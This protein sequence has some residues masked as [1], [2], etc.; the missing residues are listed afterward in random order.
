MEDYNFIYQFDGNLTDD[1]GKT[2]LGVDSGTPSYVTGDN[3]QALVGNSAALSLTL[4]KEK[5]SR[6]PAH[7]VFNLRFNTGG[8]DGNIFTLDTG[9]KTFLQFNRTGTTLE[10]KTYDTSQ[11]ANRTGTETLALDTWLCF[12][13]SLWDSTPYKEL[14]PGTTGSSFSS[15]Y[16]EWDISDY[17][18]DVKFYV[19]QTGNA[20]GVTGGVTTIATGVDIDFAV[21]DNGH[22]GY[23]Y[24]YPLG[25]GFDPRTDPAFP[26][27]NVDMAHVGMPIT[28]AQP[29]LN[30]NLTNA[31]QTL[32]MGGGGGG[33]G[34]PVIKEFWS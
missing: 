9:S 4:P 15:Y 34:G 14:E 1:T 2:T 17:G 12:G 22:E 31:V 7:F 13:L 23:E 16:N 3:G 27:N 6:R 21:F 33:G 10:T 25:A 24:I 8:T 5:F 26:V 20:S 18:T 11:T 29:P 19:G 30:A 32:P 28:I